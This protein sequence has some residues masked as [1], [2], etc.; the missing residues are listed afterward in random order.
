[1]N[2]KY[3]NNLINLYGGG[4]Y[5]NDYTSSLLK[6]YKNTKNNII[7]IKLDNLETL[8]IDDSDTE[9]DNIFRIVGGNNNIIKIDNLY[10]LITE[11]SDTFTE[12]VKNIIDLDI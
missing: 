7:I 9:D 6:K 8:L 1:M 11:E 3:L 5:T 4:D 10:N 2:N 12:I